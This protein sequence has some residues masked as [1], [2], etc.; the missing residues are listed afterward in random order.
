ML[1]QFVVFCDARGLDHVAVDAAVEWAMA[2]AG[3]EVSWWAAR[4]TVVREFSR[5][6]AAFDERTEVPPADALPRTAGR[7]RQAYLYS[8]AQITAMLRAARGF[9]NPLRAATFEASSA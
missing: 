8:P 3:A 9:A 7:A 2:P 1:G 5:F 4:L 6:Q